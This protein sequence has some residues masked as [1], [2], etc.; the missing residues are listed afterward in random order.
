MVIPL[1]LLGMTNQITAEWGYCSCIS[2]VKR[3]PRVPKALGLIF[4]ISYKAK[5]EGM[6]PSRSHCNSRPSELKIKWQGFVGRAGAQRQEAPGLSVSSGLLT[7]CLSSWHVSLQSFALPPGPSWRAC[8]RLIVQAS[9]CST[10]SLPS[11]PHLFLLFCSQV[12][13]QAI[14]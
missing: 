7:W 3:W 5:A 4:S 13:F 9:I 11:C 14:P 2:V 1:F 12:L 10:H 8:T 6:L